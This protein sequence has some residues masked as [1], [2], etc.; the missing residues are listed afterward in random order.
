M[1]ESE[2]EPAQRSQPGW[3][4]AGSFTS[5]IEH[6]IALTRKSMKGEALKM[7]EEMATAC[8]LYTSEL[9]TT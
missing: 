2:S 7:A 6:H 9:P 8:L 5:T 3:D 1:S 4:A